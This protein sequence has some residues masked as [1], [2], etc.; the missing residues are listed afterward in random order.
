[1]DGDPRAR[2]RPMAPVLDAL[3]ALGV[4]VDDGGRGALPFTVRG[5]GLGARRR[6]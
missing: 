1:M 4:E 6:R 5:A 2:E 3:R